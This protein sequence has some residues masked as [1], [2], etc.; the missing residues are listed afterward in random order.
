MLAFERA[1]DA[2]DAAAAAQRGLAGLEG[3]RVRMGLHTGQPR[4]GGKNYVGLDVHRA[5]RICAAGHGGQVLLSQATRELVEADV[6]DLGEHRL[7][8]LTQPQRLYQLVAPGLA[9]EFPPP[10][11]LENRPTNLPVQPTP[12]IG[13]ETEL[14]QVTE[15]M[16]RPDVR[17]LTLTGAGGTGKTRLALQAA[18]ELVDDYPDG[19]FFVALEAIDDPALVVPTLAQTLG[20]NETGASSLTDALRDFL[21][22]RRLLLAARQLR[23]AARR[24]GRDARGARAHP[25]RAARHQPRARSDSRASTSTRCPRSRCPRDHASP[26]TVSQYDAVA[27]FIDR[28]QSVRSDFAVTNENAPALAEICTR[29]DGLPLAIELA[30]AR[31]RLLT[32]QAMLDRLGERLALLTSGPRDLPTRQQ[33]LRGAIDWSYELLGDHEQRLFARLAVFAG[34][35][36]LD[37]AEAVCDARLDE[38]EALLENNLLRQE[39]RPDGEPRFLMLETIREYAAE[40]LDQS[41]EAASC[42]AGTRTTSCAWAAA[43]AARRRTGELYGDYVLEARGARERARRARVGTRAR[44]GGARA[45]SR[46]RDVRLLGQR[47]VPER[48]QRLAGRRAVALRRRFRAHACAGDGGRREPRLEARRSSPGR[49]RSPRRRSRCSMRH[50]DRLPL[51]HALN[52]LATCRPVARRRRRRR[53][54]PRASGSDPP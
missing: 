51:A 17:L 36:R 39:E 13:R 3:V 7:K 26:D 16:R 28:A 21:G 48:G 24:R 22:E 10:R 53:A 2:V 25:G 37:A 54:A 29:L 43:R 14:A 9:R 35:C 4:Q 46:N 42:A 49:R 41:G 12:L 6:R 50:D 34:G 31:V 1:S 19:V 8:D 44:R 5:A 47:R 30:A 18:A 38:L 20:V 45:R 32:P 11:T 40:R 15:L 52:S 23:A 33:T 27:L